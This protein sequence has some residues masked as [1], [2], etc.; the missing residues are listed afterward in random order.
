LC[1]VLAFSLFMPLGTKDLYAQMCETVGPAQ[2]EFQSLDR[3]SNEQIPEYQSQLSNFMPKD[4]QTADSEINIRLDEFDSNVRTWLE[5]WWPQFRNAI[6]SGI[7]QLSVAEPDQTRAIGSFIDAQSQVW[8]QEEIKKKEVEAHRRYRPSEMSCQVDTVSVLLGRASFVSMGVAKGYALESTIRGLN[9]LGSISENGKAPETSSRWDTYAARFCDAGINRSE[10]GPNC[11][12]VAAFSNKDLHISDA[13]WGHKKT[14]EVV[15]MVENRDLYNEMLRNMIDPFSPP[16]IPESVLETTI[17]EK[18]ILFR[19]TFEARKQAV[20]NVMGRLLGLRA[21]PKHSAVVGTDIM[22]SNVSNIRTAAGIPTGIP[23]ADPSFY[24]IMEAMT[25][26]RIRDPEYI[27]NIVDDPE[28]VMKEQAT[29]KSVHL[30]Q[31]N[32]LYK[33]FE[34]LTFLMAAELSFEL[35]QDASGSA[36]GSISTQ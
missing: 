14:Y 10:P 31:M 28:A 35:D 15:D 27:M 25:R 12:P 19:R 26:D 5:G 8:T 20:Y 7:T 32:E 21:Q 29:Q 3:L 30:Q 23:A 13:L 1:G 16:I 9:K 34:E 17:G 11:V 6:D 36:T 18:E 2:R 33:R 22:P 4:F 24:E